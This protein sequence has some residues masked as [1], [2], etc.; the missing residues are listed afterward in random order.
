[1]L[2]DI[3]MQIYYYLSVIIRIKCKFLIFVYPDQDYKF[4]N[5]IETIKKL[6]H[7]D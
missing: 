1:M 6:I 3:Q 2:V 7:R 5:F 4:Y